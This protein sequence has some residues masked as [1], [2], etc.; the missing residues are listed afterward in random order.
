MVKD[1]YLDG[2]RLFEDITYKDSYGHEFVAL[3]DGSYILSVDG[4]ETIWG[5]AYLI[6]DGMIEQICEEGQQC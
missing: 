1:F 2:L 3:P 5:E 6:K 4:V